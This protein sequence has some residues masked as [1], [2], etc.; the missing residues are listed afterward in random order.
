MNEAVLLKLDWPKLLEELGKYAQTEAGRKLCVSLVPDLSHE[1]I[2]E[3]WERVTPLTNLLR[4]GYRPPIGELQDMEPVLRAVRVGQILS[5][6]LFRAIAQLL[7]ATKHTHIFCGDF[8]ER[9][10]PL[11][12]FRA[13]F[14]PLPK[15]S[16]AIEITIAPD[17]TLLD[18]A[19]PQLQALRASKVTL[20]RRIENQLKQIMTT[21]EVEQYLQ[22]TF[23]T[24]RS[25]RYV[26][27]IRVDGR[28]RIKGFIYDTSDSGQTLFMEPLAIAS[29]NEQLLELELSEKIEIMRIFRELS[30]KIAEELEPLTINYEKLIELDFLSAQAQL[31]QELDAV[32]VQL[33]TTP[34]LNLIDARHPLLRSADKKPPVANT[35]QLKSPQVCLIISGPNAGGKTVVMKTVGL[36]HLMAKA[37]L[38]VPAAAQSQMFVFDRVL[39]E[40]GD[41]Q[42]LSANLSTFSGH[43]FGLKPIVENASD[44]DL[45]L[46]DELAVGTEPQTGGALAQAILESLAGRNTFCLTTTHFDNL[47]SLAV[48]N[49]QFRNG[50]MEFSTKSLKP[51][52]KLILDVPGQSYGLEVAEQMGFPIEVIRRAKKLRG[53]AATALDEAVSQLMQ[54]REEAQL[55]KDELQQAKLAAE[56]AQA[57]WQEERLALEE[58]RKKAAAKLAAKYEAEVEALRIEFES[59]VKDMRSVLKQAQHG[60]GDIEGL[61]R[62]LLDSKHAADKTLEKLSGSIHDLEATGSAGSTAPGKEAVFTDLRKGDEIYVSSL[63]KK[64]VITKLGLSHDDPIEVQSGSVKLRTAVD[65]LRILETV[66]AKPAPRPATKTPAPRKATTDDSIP[67]VIQTP[68]NTVDLRGLD[69]DAATSKMWQFIDQA[70]MRGESIVLIVHGHGT[71]KLKTTLRAQLE[72]NSPYAIRFRPGMAE[73]GGDGV[74]VIA[75]VDK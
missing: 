63:G 40:M 26:I 19:S 36:L 44:H 69:A 21:P 58:T 65:N 28:G 23:F 2:T 27:P 24:I 75:L 52:Y 33:S 18:T 31:A 12:H 34:I 72:K 38:L 54:A 50:S 42:N 67:F 55:N 6:D 53:S 7:N 10:T 64:G 16:Q 45:V 68:T 60:D 73:E 70:V 59:N 1:Q 35:I 71:D 29:L 25:E 3:R 14:Y 47:K 61:R 62:Q 20:R 4:Q 30:M 46:L 32:A 48:T 11:K 17:G 51:T 43:V 49:R 74:T 13:N 5:G 22:D 56:E 9:C 8:A 41:A 37:G 66:S 15:L 39:I 57:R